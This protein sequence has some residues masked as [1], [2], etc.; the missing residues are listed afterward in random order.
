VTWEPV[1]VRRAASGA[2]G[3]PMTGRTGGHGEWTARRD[4]A[5]GCRA[6]PAGSRRRRTRTGPRCGHH[7]IEYPTA[8][9]RPP[10]DDRRPHRRPA[11]PDPRPATP[12]DPR[13][14]RGTPYNNL[15]QATTTTST[16]SATPRG[17][18]GAGVPGGGSAVPADQPGDPGEHRSL[19]PRAC[20]A[21]VRVGASGAGD[22]AG[23][24]VPAGAVAGAGDGARAAARRDPYGHRRPAANG[25]A[26]IR[27]R[28]GDWVPGPNHYPTLAVSAA[29]RFP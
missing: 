2:A 7:P 11:R 4:P 17:S 27:R 15:I 22:R 1:G 25:T 23:V 29:A 21:A 28:V 8:T 12:A 18:G 3:R 5:T 14:R 9:T 24:A 26:L 10:M 20:L 19:S 13:P 6:P 16:S